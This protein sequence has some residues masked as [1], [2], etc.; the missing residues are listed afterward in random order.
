MS[1]TN[2]PP[3]QTAEVQIHRVALQ[4]NKEKIIHPQ[5]PMNDKQCLA[6]FVNV[7]GIDTWTL[8][9]SGSTMSGVTPTF[10]QIANVKVSTP[11]MHK[12]KVHLDF[13]QLT[14][15]IDR[16][17]VTAKDIVGDSDP[18]IHWHRTMGKHQE[19]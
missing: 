5:V 1:I 18:R 4:K 13:E 19:H 14:V 3:E 6:S 11:F 15:V 2:G 17:T 12:H 9:D 10:A 7:N 16:E 8:W